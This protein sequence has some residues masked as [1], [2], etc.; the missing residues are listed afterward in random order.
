MQGKEG[1]AKFIPVSL[2]ELESTILP[3]HIDKAWHILKHFRL[4]DIIPSYV[5]KSEFTSGQPG[6]I[7]SI[8]RVSF[9]DGAV[10][11]IRM[12][13]FSEIRRSIAYEV[14]STEPAHKASSIQGSIVLKPVTKEE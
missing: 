8:V 10:W 2:Y 11:E 9:A 12:V 6:L 7:D 5:K 14:L 4:E 1:E 3:V 13:E